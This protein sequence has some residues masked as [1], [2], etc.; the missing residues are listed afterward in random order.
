MPHPVALG[1]VQA[2]AD[3]SA[4]G[5][6]ADA[7]VVLV[8]ADLHSSAARKNLSGAVEIYSRA[9]PEVTPGRRLVVKLQSRDLSTAAFSSLRADAARRSDIVWIDRSMSTPDTQKLIASC[10]VLLS[11]HRSEGFGLHLAEAFM[12]GI[13]AL[14]TGWSGNLD[15]MSVLPELLIRHTLVPVRDPQGIYPAKGVW[16]EPDV[17]DAVARLKMLSGSSSLR[18]DLAAKGRSSVESLSLAW[19]PAALAQ[20]GLGRW[21]K[22]G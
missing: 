15:F 12:L 5:L 18:A 14:A 11:P 3:R 17:A 1:D 6:P 21:T 22:Q 13:P 20:T 10:D 16:A 8:M 9:F 19:T 7:L 2:T 4:F